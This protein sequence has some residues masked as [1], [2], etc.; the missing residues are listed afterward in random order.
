MPK[1]G[2][3]LSSGEVAVLRRWIAEGAVWPKDH[4][5]QEKARA[6][7]SWWSLRPLA[8]VK[9]PSRPLSGELPDA[10]ADNPIDRFVLVKLFEKGLRPSPPA[11]RRTLIR[12]VTYDLTGL[13]PTPE[14]VDAFVADRRPVAYERLVDR[15]LA[16]PHYGERWGRHWLDVVRFGESVGFERNIIID[17]AWPF[18]DHVI[19]SFNADKPFDQ[20]VLDHL[21]GDVVG[22]GDPAVEVGTG[23]LVCGAYDNVKNLD[24]RADGPEPSQRDRRHGPGHLGSLPRPDDRL[25]PLPQPQVRPDPPARLL[26]S[27]GHLRRAS[28][29]AAGWSP[30]PKPA[31]PTRRV[32]SSC[33][34]NRPGSVASGP[35]SKTR[36]WPAAASTPRSTKPA[37][38]ARRPSRPRRSRPSHPILARFVRLIVTGRLD[39][40]ELATGYGI[41]EFEVWTAGD[42]S[43]NVALATNGGARRRREPAGE[44]LRRRLQCEARNR[45]SVRC[46][47]DR[48]RPR[49]DDHAGETG[50]DRPGRVLEQPRPRQQDEVL[51]DPLR[52]GIPRRGLE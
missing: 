43:R 19:R 28:G 47:L 25:C 29:T 52:G 8:D 51:P 3:P 31:A 24:P 16:S 20:L 41:D 46:G 50:A 11:D 10:W 37:G 17:N 27:P 1:K 15:L 42:G 39:N 33:R 4:V 6:D 21:A 18:R 22:R 32:S 30:R 23:F 34:P 9:P 12:R 2:E 45:R 13:P 48:R 5:I 36:S 44:R 26:Q 14:E 49:A 40:P 7:T 38:S 35:A